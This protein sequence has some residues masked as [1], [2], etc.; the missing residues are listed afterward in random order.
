MPADWD[1]VEPLIRELGAIRAAADET[2]AE[3]AAAAA[4]DAAIAAAA[5]AIG[6][7]IAAPP[8]SP[9]LA[10]ARETIA[11]ARALV[12]PVTAEIHRGPTARDRL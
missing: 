9:A 7:S 11:S 10:H 2:R 5:L 6:D 4:V 8:H 1:S 3:K 12:A